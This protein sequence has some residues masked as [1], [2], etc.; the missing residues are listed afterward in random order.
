M[1]RSGKVK[2]VWCLFCS[3]VFKGVKFDVIVYRIMILG[4]FREG[5]WCEVD[6]LCR[7][8]KEDGIIM[9]IKCIYNDEIFGD[10]YYISLLLVEFIKVIYE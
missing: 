5:W 4:L 3:F 8:M 10:N 7:K 2:E 6:K 1:C 9:L